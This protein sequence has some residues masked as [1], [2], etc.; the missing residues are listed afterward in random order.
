MGISFFAVSEVGIDLS[1]KA[2]V[3]VSVLDGT[4]GYHVA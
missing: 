1:V 3:A 4:C 2:L